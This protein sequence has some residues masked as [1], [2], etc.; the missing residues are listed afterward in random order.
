MS[1]GGVVVGTGGNRH[2]PL[3]AH[4]LGDKADR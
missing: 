2:G 1:L 3:G 4:G